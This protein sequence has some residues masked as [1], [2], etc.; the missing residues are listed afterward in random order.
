[1]KQAATEMHDEHLK[2]KL[3]KAVAAGR[4]TQAQADE[5]YAWYQARPDVAM[6][7]GM[8]KHGFGGRGHGR[9][10]GPGMDGFGMPHAPAQT[11]PPTPQG[12]GA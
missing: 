11:T 3:A 5:L 4:I 1:M 8:G 9:M 10:F 7:L 2:A 12:S 6:G